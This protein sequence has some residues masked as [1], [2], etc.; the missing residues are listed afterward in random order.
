M[1]PQIG[2]LWTPGYW[3]WGGGGFFSMKATG[4]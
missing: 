1:A 3:G 4:A 2:F